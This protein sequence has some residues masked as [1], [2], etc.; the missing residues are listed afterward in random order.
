MTLSLLEIIAIPVAVI[1][2]IAFLVVWGMRGRGR[3]IECPECGATFKRPAFAAKHYG[4]GVSVTGLGDFTCPKCKY[5]GSVSSFKF[6]DEA[7]GSTN[8]DT[9]GNT[10]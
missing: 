10:K 5:K 7:V 6:V 4:V 8:S 1:I 2:V 3:L 9:Q